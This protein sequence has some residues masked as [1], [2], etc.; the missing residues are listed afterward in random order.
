M[1]IIFLAAI[2]AIPLIGLSF[3]PLIVN[4]NP[5]QSAIPINNPI[6]RK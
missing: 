6:K 1:E 4:G 5:L 2:M 3:L